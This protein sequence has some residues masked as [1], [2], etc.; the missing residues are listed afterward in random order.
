[1][2]L[3]EVMSELNLT[4]YPEIALVMFLCIFAGVVRYVIVGHKRDRWEAARHMPLVDD[5]VFPQGD[6][7]DKH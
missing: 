7:H 3:S 4:L 2:R 1:M 5:D 6:A